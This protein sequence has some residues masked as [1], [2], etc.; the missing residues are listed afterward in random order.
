VANPQG[1][2]IK[3]WRKVWEHPFFKEKRSFSKFEAWVD[4]ILMADHEDNQ[5]I[6]KGKVIDCKRGEIITSERFLENRWGWSRD[7]LRRFLTALE[8]GQPALKPQTNRQQTATHTTIHIINYDTYQSNQTSPNT[9]N[10][11]QTRPQTK[12]NTRSIKELNNKELNNKES[13]S[14]SETKL[15]LTYYAEQFKNEFGTDPIVEWGKDG[16]I[17]K[18]LLKF[19]PLE[20]LK[21]LLNKFF[22]SEDK[23]IQKSGYTI[24]V[25]KSQ[26]N[27]LKISQGTRD[28]MD[29]WLTVKEKQDEKRRQE[30]VRTVNEKTEG[31]IPDQFK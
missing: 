25:F 7:K 12:P 20:N 19:I 9:T 28:G 29:L 23:F 2:W 8:E 30:E 3:L 27:K 26:L 6:I 18:G 1:G 10:K 4:M 31:H 13:I 17:I 24:G 21:D 11:P 15:F 5:R 16:K 22:S 14:H